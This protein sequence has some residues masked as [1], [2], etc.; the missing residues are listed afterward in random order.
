M[1]LIYCTQLWV[2]G[3]DVFHMSTLLYEASDLI[4]FTTVILKVDKFVACYVLA[5]CKVISGLE[6]TI[7]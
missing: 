6:N 5:T 7:N 1:E 2:A 3:R 4:Q